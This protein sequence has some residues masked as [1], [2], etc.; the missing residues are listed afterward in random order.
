MQSKYVDVRNLSSFPL[1]L[2]QTQSRH[3]QDTLIRFNKIC[4]KSSRPTNNKG[5]SK[6]VSLSEDQHNNYKQKVNQSKLFKEHIWNLQG[7]RKG[8]TKSTKAKLRMG[9]E[10]KGCI[11]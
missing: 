8:T 10:D 9:V 3:H 1:G 5:E 7:M 4:T 6:L 2:L 11:F